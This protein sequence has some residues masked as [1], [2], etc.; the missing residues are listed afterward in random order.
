MDI[1]VLVEIPYVM[2]DIK[3]INA[4]IAKIKYAEQRLQK[5]EEENPNH[6]FYRRNSHIM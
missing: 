6:P 4:K 3:R 1:N 2:K 5:W